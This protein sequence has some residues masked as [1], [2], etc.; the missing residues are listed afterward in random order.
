MVTQKVRI[1][2]ERTSARM[3]ARLLREGH[4]VT[5]LVEGGSVDEWVKDDQN[6]HPHPIG[7]VIEVELED[8][9]A[10]DYQVQ[11]VKE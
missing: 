1:T 2:D 3:L 5:T 11:E 9:E 8:M 4:A 10:E 7:E 6:V